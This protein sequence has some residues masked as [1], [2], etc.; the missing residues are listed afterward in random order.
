[1]LI[2]HRENLDLRARERESVQL[3]QGKTQII[4]QTACRRRRSMFD[5]DDDEM[6]FSYELFGVALAEVFVAVQ[7]HH[8]P[9]RRKKISSCVWLFAFSHVVKYYSYVFCIHWKINPLRAGD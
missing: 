1:M 2:L 4:Y 6:Q 5:H 3:I 9:L 7:S 8:I